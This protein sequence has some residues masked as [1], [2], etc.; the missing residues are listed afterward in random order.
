MNTP[1]LASVTRKS[2]ARFTEPEPHISTPAPSTKLPPRAESRSA[3]EARVR[4]KA[5]PPGTTDF[6][7]P[8]HEQGA[9]QV[10]SD[11]RSVAEA[12]ACSCGIGRPKR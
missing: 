6:P 4:D 10:D 2:V 8:R 12:L 11:A 1:G 5:G 3:I 7:A 9:T